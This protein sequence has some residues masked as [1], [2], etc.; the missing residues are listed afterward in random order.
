MAPGALL[1]KNDSPPA[2]I[3]DND[4]FT[5]EPGPIPAAHPTSLLNRNVRTAS[6]LLKRAEGNWRWIADDRGTWK[7]FD[8]SGGA[9]VSSIDPRE[10]RVRD[11]ILQ[12]YDTGVVYAPGGF[13]TD[14]AK[15]FAQFLIRTTDNKMSKAV[16]YSSG[17]IESA[18]SQNC[19][20]L[21]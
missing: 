4:S 15:E 11:A 9:A 1:T 20:N 16:F 18:M 19:V 3:H 7:I 10:P 17:I 12:Q 13:E 8:G 2:S 14:I 6:L 21:S 5:I